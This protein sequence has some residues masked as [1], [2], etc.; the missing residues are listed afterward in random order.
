[1]DE[2]MQSTIES[3]CDVG[4]ECAGLQFVVMIFQ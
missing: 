3:T 4:M 1:M 2:Y